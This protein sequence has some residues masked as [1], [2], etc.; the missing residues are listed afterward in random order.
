[1]SLEM[2]LSRLSLPNRKATVSI[3][4]DSAFVTSNWLRDCV[5]QRSVKIYEESAAKVDGWEAGIRTPIPWSRGGRRSVE[6]LG[7]SV[8]F[9]R[10]TV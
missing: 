3:C 8:S 1:M 4:R 7:R 2:S 9:L 5:S 10:S 6:D